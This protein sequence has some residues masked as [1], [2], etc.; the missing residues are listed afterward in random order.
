VVLAAYRQRDAAGVYLA[1]GC[2]GGDP[3]FEAVDGNGGFRIIGDH[4]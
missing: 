3:V 4:E 2:L 1:L